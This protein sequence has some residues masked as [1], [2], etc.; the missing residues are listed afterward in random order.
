M[1]LL[2]GVDV[3]IKSDIY[4]VTAMVHPESKVIGTSS[5][6][7]LNHLGVNISFSMEVYHPAH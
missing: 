2:T 7:T 1:I 6:P 4:G 5:L 3:L